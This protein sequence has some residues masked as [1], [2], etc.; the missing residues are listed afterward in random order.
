MAYRGIF[1]SHEFFTPVQSAC[2][3]ET[4][5]TDSSLVVA[6]PYYPLDE[7]EGGGDG[8]ADALTRAPRPRPAPRPHAAGRMV[9]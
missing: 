1:G 5:Y 2:L 6:G 8:G 7:R 4:L 3:D 9:R